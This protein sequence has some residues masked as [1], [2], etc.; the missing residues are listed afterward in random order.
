[1]T[2][3]LKELTAG[4]GNS[5]Q[6]LANRAADNLAAGRSEIAVLAG[7]EGWNTMWRSR[8]TGKNQTKYT[9]RLEIPTV[10][11]THRGHPPEGIDQGADNPVDY[12]ALFENVLRPTMRGTNR[13]GLGDPAYPAIPRREMRV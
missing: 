5:P 12:F 7:C 8:R 10:G 3:S 13:L 4:G 11:I 2:P 9:D 6:W 1:M